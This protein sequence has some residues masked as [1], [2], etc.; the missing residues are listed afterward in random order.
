MGP[1]RASATMWSA[2]SPDGA[3]RGS[4]LDL[5]PLTVRSTSSVPRPELPPHR[6]R[7]LRLA[8]AG[9]HGSLLQFFERSFQRCNRGYVVVAEPS[10]D[11]PVGLPSGQRTRLT[12]SSFK[13][14]PP[15][16]SAGGGFLF[17]PCSAGIDGG[18]TISSYARCSDAFKAVFMIQAP[19]S[20][21]RWRGSLLFQAAA[22]AMASAGWVWL[23]AYAEACRRALQGFLAGEGSITPSAFLDALMA[24]SPAAGGEF[25]F[26]LG[27]KTTPNPPL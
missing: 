8:V 18:G 13:P 2:A 20:A 15:S 21:P 5:P 16:P 11:T 1:A 7:C 24:A 6:R 17:Q 12:C 27:A 4:R 14:Q 19:P 22:P 26:R 10:S 9:H 23:Q 25:L 3:V